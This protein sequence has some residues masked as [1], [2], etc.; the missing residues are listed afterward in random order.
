MFFPLTSKFPKNKKWLSQ[1]KKMGEGKA[2]ASKGNLLF[3]ITIIVK[4][5]NNNRLKW[6][7][8]ELSTI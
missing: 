3:M 1:V 7:I 2:E 4:V 5:T 8:R 6:S